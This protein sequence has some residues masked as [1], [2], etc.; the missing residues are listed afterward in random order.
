MHA[1]RDEKHELN[2]QCIALTLLHKIAIDYNAEQASSV[3]IQGNMKRFTVAMPN[4]ALYN[5][6]FYCS[7]AS[8]VYYS[9]TL[10]TLNKNLLAIILL[11]SF[12][13]VVCLLIVYFLFD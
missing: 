12:T 4:C 13:F 5:Y 11:V 8:Y 7:V 2:K 1:G 9:K 6:I 3:L 10:Y